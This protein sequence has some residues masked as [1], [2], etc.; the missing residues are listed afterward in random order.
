MAGIHTTS[1]R[2]HSAFVLTFAALLGWF[3][4]LS[5]TGEAYGTWEPTSAAILIVG[6]PLVMLLWMHARR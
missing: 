3:I 2:I 4:A 5:V 1:P 6:I